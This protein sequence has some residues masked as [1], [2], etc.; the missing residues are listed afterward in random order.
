MA[1]VVSPGD[2]EPAPSPWL[3]RPARHREGHPLNAGMPLRLS[4]WAYPVVLVRMANAESSQ[5][6]HQ[7]GRIGLRCATDAEAVARLDVTSH[8]EHPIETGFAAGS[9]VL[10]RSV[11]VQ[12]EV[13]RFRVH[14][15]VV[16][17]NTFEIE[18][19]SNREARTCTLLRLWLFSQ[20]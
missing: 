18:V 4:T 20:F 3:P 16:I 13:P 12:L 5:Q 7:M 6:L 8:Q 2:G 14:A 11:G 17:G 1:D 19:G 9:Q 10:Q 15:C